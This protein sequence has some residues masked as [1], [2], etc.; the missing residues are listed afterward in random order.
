MEAAGVNRA[1]RVS[2]SRSGATPRRPGR[3]KGGVSFG[4]AAVNSPPAART[5]STLPRRASGLQS[6]S[7]R[8]QVP[9]LIQRPDTALPV[10]G[11]ERE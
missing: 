3:S 8:A 11:P 1:P 6:L 9:G 5:S 4:H 10:L 7:R 2:A